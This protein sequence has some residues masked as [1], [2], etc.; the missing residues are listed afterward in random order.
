[1]RIEELIEENMRLHRASEIEHNMNSSPK[2][3]KDNESENISRL[4]QTVNNIT[5]EKSALNR[6]LM[7]K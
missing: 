2:A 1:M 6:M 3:K 7:E 4:N 5:A